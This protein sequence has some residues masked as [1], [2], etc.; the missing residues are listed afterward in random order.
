MSYPYALVGDVI[1]ATR[2]E[3]GSKEIVDSGSAEPR[4]PNIDDVSFVT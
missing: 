2:L 1:A 4:I 3:D